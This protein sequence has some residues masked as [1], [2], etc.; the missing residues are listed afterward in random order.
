[1]IHRL[2][3][4]YWLRP[5]EDQFSRFFVVSSSSTRFLQNIK[6]IKAHCGWTTSLTP[7]RRQIANHLRG[8]SFC[9]LNVVEAKGS[10]VSNFDWLRFNRSVCPASASK[11]PP[12]EATRRPPPL[13]VG[14]PSLAARSL[15]QRRKSMFEMHRV[16]YL[17]LPRAR[18]N[19][20]LPGFALG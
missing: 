11:I 13:V 10:S 17:G 19:R 9:M 8:S 15:T 7:R 18:K 4:R 16:L 20:V 5:I 3:K 14:S 2:F 1:M 12:T 6:Q